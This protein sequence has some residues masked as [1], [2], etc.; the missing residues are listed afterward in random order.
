MDGPWPIQKTKV[1]YNVNVH[2]NEVE[3]QFAC[4]RPT[5]SLWWAQANSFHKQVDHHS[6]ATVLKEGKAIVQTPHSSKTIKT[7]KQNFTK[8]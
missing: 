6:Y 7:V 2:T 3:K 5:W 8:Y 4:L 1:I